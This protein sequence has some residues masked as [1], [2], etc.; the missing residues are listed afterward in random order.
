MSNERPFVV[1]QSV[2]CTV[3]EILSILDHEGIVMAVEDDYC[4]VKFLT[5]NKRINKIALRPR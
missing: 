5:K 1:G 4:L 3:P 2:I